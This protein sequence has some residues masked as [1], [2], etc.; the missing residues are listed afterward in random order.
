MTVTRLDADVLELASVNPRSERP[1][2][3]HRHPRQQSSA[4]VHAGSL[5]FEIEGREQR[6]GP[7]ESVTIPAGALHTFW[8]ES[9]EEAHS[10][11]TFRPAMETAA[12]FETYAVLADRGELDRKGMPGLLQLAVM[13]PEFG[14]EI[15]VTRP[16]WLAQRVFAAV[17]G[18]VARRR[19]YRARLEQS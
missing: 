3:R 17:L 5:V 13:V 8:N 15:R 16:P 10:T 6:I 2:P 19:G 4:A 14:E 7:G 9:D 18:P 11:Q 1:E 12:F